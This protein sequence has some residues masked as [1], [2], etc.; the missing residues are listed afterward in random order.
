MAARLQVLDGTTLLTFTYDD[1][2]RYA[3]PHSPAGVAMAFQ[4]MRGA[5]PRLDPE[6]APRRREISVDTAFRGPGGRDG[7]ELVTRAVTGG[8]YTVTADLERAELGMASEQF[9]FRLRYRDVACTLAVRRGLVTDEFVLMARKED[10]TPAEE[11]EFTA[12]KQAM[13]D[14]VLAATPDNVFD[15]E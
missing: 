10:R 2:L 8:R 5:F 4:A 9:V 15:I 14:Q 1:L 12:M 7:F 3:G 6:A 13:A 11:Q